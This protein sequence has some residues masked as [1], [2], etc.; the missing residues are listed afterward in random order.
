MTQHIAR[1]T[2]SCFYQLRWLRRIRRPIGQELVAQLVHLFVLSRLDY[3]NSA[4]SCHCNEFRT[5]PR[6]WF[7]TYGWTNTWHQL[8]GSSTG[9]PLTVEW[10]SNCAPWCTQSTLV[11][12]RRT[13]PTRCMLSPPARRGPACD[14]PTPLKTQRRA[15]EPRSARAR[16]RRPFCL[17]RSP[18][19]TP[20]HHG[21]ETF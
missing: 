19:V 12:V 4:I 15:V 7:S 3:G 6:D 20:H 21:L 1:V 2:S 11:S 17:E 18:S 8:W 9:Y 10:T 16:P 5:P 14:P 13:S